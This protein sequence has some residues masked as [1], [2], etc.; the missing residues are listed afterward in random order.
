MFLRNFVAQLLICVVFEENKHSV[1]ARST[2]NGKII[3]SYEKSFEDRKKLLQYVDTLSQNFQ[4]YYISVFCDN[5]AQGL[6]PVSS[7]SELSRFGAP[8]NV[9][10]L[11]LLN[12]QIYTPKSV[13]KEYQKLF[14]DYGEVD[15]IYSPFMLLYHCIGKT[16]PPKDKT[17]LYVFRHSIY[18][19]L[20]VCETKRILFGKFYDVS[21]QDFEGEDISTEEVSTDT[22]NEMS[23]EMNFDEPLANS[24]A[25]KEL[26]ALINEDKGAENS[27][28]P[29][30]GAEN[31]K[32]IAPISAPPPM[33]DANTRQ[34]AS[35]AMNLS[36][37]G[38]DMD[39]C[40]C[41]FKGVQ[42]FYQNPLYNGKFIDE[43][44]FF[45]NTE[46][47]QAVLDYIEGEIFIKPKVVKIDTFALMSELMRKEL[48]L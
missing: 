13:I 15:L 35:S 44:V 22:M 34:I 10:T 17:T 32:K 20:M 42:E 1:K 24:E 6:A 33:N 45:D 31:E 46:I 19:A 7:A 12:A 41:I 4:L 5:A 38:S 36:N 11:N 2:K 26:G 47:S 18:L 8:K 40:A 23:D 30:L 16:K 28:A 48:E 39:M 27:D 43:L 37:F 29:N 14:E 25:G 3:K 9:A 21:V